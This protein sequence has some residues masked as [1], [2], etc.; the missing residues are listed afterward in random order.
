MIEL[1]LMIEGQDGVDWP[2]WQR[3]A[4]IAE[5]GGFAG[6]YRSD[7]WTNPG[8]PYK[9]SLDCWV[10]LAWLASSTKRIEFGPLVSPVSFRD[11]RMLAR[12]AAA[13]DDLSDGRLRLGLG[14][15]WQEREHTAFGYPLLERGPRFKR[16]REALEVVSQMLRCDEPFSFDGEYYQLREALLTPRP[17][18]R[19]PIVIGGNGANVTLSLAAQYADEWNCVYRTP[20]AF[21][22]LSAT[23][24]QKLQ[25]RGRKP[26]DVK[27]TMMTGVFLARDKAELE[28]RL[29]GR[30]PESLRGER[31]ALV[32]SPSELRDQLSALESAGVQRVMLQWLQIDD[33]EGMQALAK[34]LC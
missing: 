1:A 29:G 19:T 33:F 22:E 34:A 7:H 27:R 16:F 24:D 3:I 32:G 20:Q 31:G 13:I 21:R 5:D 2:T 15:G 26:A 18:R 28:R 14:A 4:K 17:K 25:E 30:E 10:S 23:L 11:P 6:L 12:Q 8:G 9:D